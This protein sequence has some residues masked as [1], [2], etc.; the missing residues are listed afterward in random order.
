M[1]LVGSPMLRSVMIGGFL[2][3]IGTTTCI[4]EEMVSAG[5]G[6]RSCADFARDYASVHDAETVYFA[7]AQGAMSTINSTLGLQQHVYRN[8][9]AV[10]VG[11]QMSFLRNYCDQH[12]LGNYSDAIIALM[13]TL[14]LRELTPAG[15]AN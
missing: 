10:T 7:W 14:P 9:A 2:L 8:L 15:R 11:E 12:P 13:Q 6:T 3:I 4:A 5:P 1:K